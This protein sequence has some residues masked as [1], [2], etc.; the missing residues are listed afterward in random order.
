MKFT[1]FAMPALAIASHLGSMIYEPMNSLCVV[2]TVVEKPVHVNTCFPSRTVATIAG[3][4]TTISSATCIDTIVTESV[5][6]NPHGP[7]AAHR[8][9][10]YT[11]ITTDVL[12]TVCPSPT[13][14]TY[15]TKVYTITKAT[16]LTITGEL[17]VGA[18]I[19]MCGED[20]G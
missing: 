1:I 10:D 15:G 12:K 13:I 14:F 8:P 18:K 11:T 6:L 16:T 5:T 7:T 20:Y 3:C 2:Y 9:V 4:T 17:I 19:Q